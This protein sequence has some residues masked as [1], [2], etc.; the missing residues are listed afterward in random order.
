M[1]TTLRRTLTASVTTAATVLGLTMLTAPAAHAATDARITTIDYAG[2]GCA[3]SATT[4]IDATGTK[5]TITF[6]RYRADVGRDVNLTDSYKNCNLILTVSMPTL[7]NLTATVTHSTYCD[8]KQDVE[9]Q[10][11]GFV[12]AGGDVIPATFSE[13]FTGPEEGRCD[14]SASSTSAVPLVGEAIVQSYSELILNN[15]A[16]RRH[17]GFMITEVAVVQLS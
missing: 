8:L 14:V 15:S 11:R 2:S 16:N 17:S 3:G 7:R 12:R 5:A 13:T 4:D 10:S 1:R 9:G 6:E